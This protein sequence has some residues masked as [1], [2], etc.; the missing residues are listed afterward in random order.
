MPENYTGHQEARTGDAYAGIVFAQNL[1]ENQQGVFSKPYSEYI[2]VKLDKPLQLGNIYQLQYFIN[3]SGPRQSNFEYALC[4]NS[5]GALFTSFE[6]NEKHDSIIQLTPQFNSDLNDFYCD[7]SKW[8]EI[9][10]TF[11]AQSNE[12]FLTIGVFTPMPFTKVTD[13]TGDV[14]SPQAGRYYYIDDVSLIDLGDLS[15]IKNTIPNVFTPNGDGVNDVL[16]MDFL[17]LEP[18]NVTIVNRWGNVVYQTNKGSQWDGTHNEEPC[19][20]G[21]YYYLIEFTEEIKINSFIHLIR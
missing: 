6:L 4:P 3:N 11:Q 9:S 12:K 14:I 2:Q 13:L 16:T 15:A 20:D 5:I 8:H 1:I 21:V 10:Y 7:T 17:G 19:T 18:S